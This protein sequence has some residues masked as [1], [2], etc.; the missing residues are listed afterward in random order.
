[1]SASIPPTPPRWAERILRAVVGTGPEGLSILGDAREELEIRGANSWFGSRVWYW[2]YVLRFA[3]TYRMGGKGALQGL[4]WDIKISLRSLVRRPWLTGAVLSTLAVG[5]GTSTLAYTL[6]DG[7][8]LRP[9]AYPAPE[10]LV[11]VSRVDPDWYGGAPTAREAGGVF[12]TPAAT[13]RDWA[14]MARSYSAFGAF[15]WNVSTFTGEQDPERVL[16]VVT[17]SGVFSALSVPPALGRHLVS[18]DDQPGAGPVVVLSHALW[19]RRFAAS[20]DLVGRAVT[21]DGVVH[22]VVGVMPPDFAFPDGDTDFW[23][24]FDDDIHASTMRNGGFLHGLGRLAPGVTVEQA[25]NEM[26][27]ITGRLAEQYPVEGEFITLVF[28]RQDVVVAPARSGLL[29]LMVSALVVLLVGCANVA[30]LLLARVTERRRELAVHS[31]LGAA[32]RRIATLVLGESVTLAFVGG[33]LGVGL[34]AWAMGTFLAAF[35]IDLPSGVDVSLDGRVVAIALLASLFVGVM[36][37]LLP[38]LRA[39]Q[40]DLNGVLRDGD[41]GATGG[42]GGARSRSFLVVSEVALAVLLL[43]TSG[44]LLQGY[45]REASADRGFE[46]A[47]VLSARIAPTEVTL[48]SPDA[49]RAFYDRLVTQIEALPGV[50]TVGLAHQM[51]YSGGFSAPPSSVDTRGGIV[52]SA[53]HTSIVTP[54]YFET[55]GIPLIRGR[56]F[57]DAD[58]AGT[59]PITV[60]SEAMVRR[61]WPDEDPLGRRVRLDTRD[62]PEWLEVVGVVGDIRYGF[63]NVQAVEYYRLFEQ[64]PRST[65]SIAVKVRPGAPDPT[66]DIERIVHEMDPT[67]PV[68]VRSLEE[69]AA[70]DYGQETS[71]ATSLLLSILAAVSTGLAVLG[72]YS[73]LA[74]GVVQRRKEI[75]IRASLGG[76]AFEILTSVLKGGLTLCGLG[77]V[78]GLTLALGGSRLLS[79]ATT[80]VPQINLSVVVGVVGA[81]T[82]T[83]VLASLVPAWRAARVDPLVAFRED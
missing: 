62:D 61:F 16:G 30:N 63:G 4:R 9:L 57:S 46:P 6:V 81:M 8:L 39:G 2:G 7:V 83:S 3:A 76:S 26:V 45:L 80:A 56:A 72:V 23:I 44:S 64:S 31:A 74:Y 42:K 54:G 27:D 43:T 29:L 28:G 66:T 32:R 55:L 24:G 47:G 75:G 11:E 79:S 20:R 67:M 73:V 35:P 51:P 60:V 53:V 38:L 1:M 22:T 48:D 5:I 58:A 52:E 65:Q 37:G 41:R 71:R 69:R 36:I 15:A 50:T 10:E 33:A 77:V 34:A 13:Y 40:L 59:L 19:T 49:L 21:M 25:R 12:A 78:L 18:A 82:V 17:T 68:G 70:D 14:N